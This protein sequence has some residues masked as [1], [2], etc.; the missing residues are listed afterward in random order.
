MTAV[1]QRIPGYLRLHV[2]GFP[3]DPGA[4]D[5]VPGLNELCGAFQRATG[6]SLQPVPDADEG[7]YGA[8][9]LTSGARSG[10]RDAAATRVELS[11]SDACEVSDPES[12]AIRALAGSI[13]GLL[14]DLHRTRT[15]LWHR[16][17]ELAAGVPVTLHPDGEA[18]LA[19]RLESVLKAAAQAVDCQ[20]AAAYLLDEDTRQ[21]KLRTCWGLPKTRFL[22]SPR[23]LRGA[24]ADLEAL[25]GHAV[26]VEDALLAQDWRMPEEFRSAVC[27]PISSPTTLL[28]TLWMFCQRPRAFGVEETNLMEIV[29]GRLAADLERE[30]LLQQTLQ[31]RSLK[32]QLG[33]AAL[34]QDGR[35]PRIKPLMPRWQLAGWTDQ[36]DHVGG[37]FHDW[38]V[39]PD[40][41][42]AVAVGDAQGKMIEA[43]L[44]AASLHTALRSHANYRHAA[45]ELIARVNE[46]MWTA[47]A[48]DQFASLFYGLIQPDSG[49]L[50]YASAGHTYATVVGE[51]IRPLSGDEQFPL[52]T[53]PDVEYPTRTERIGP[54]EALV[55]LSEGIKRSVRPGKQRALWRF[56]QQHRRLSADD[57]VG[58]IQD[59]LAEH[60]RDGR[61]E[62][63]TLLVVKRRLR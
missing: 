47:S 44:T 13:N 60:R 30:M 32:R 15:E 50:E 58:K 55:V 6:W 24:A 21:L 17:A 4:V 27:V 28:G 33:Y 22:E 26:V 25:V 40:G 18:H 52:G 19:A 29:A 53:Q 45:H 2:E 37:D 12:S 61:T 63:R 9:L 8:D 7:A 35:L 14:R 54:E 36:G 10:D 23:A 59:Y 34:W 42:V 3:H 39:L 31:S 43:G 16:E 38:F 11:T 20:A 49:E 46:T 51:Q 1:T 41:S 48:G 5:D 62:D 57:L 56:V